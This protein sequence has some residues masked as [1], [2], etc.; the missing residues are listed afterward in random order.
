MFRLL[1]EEHLTETRDYD[2]QGTAAPQ[3]LK[4]KATE[5]QSA[6]NTLQSAAQSAGAGAVNTA[7]STLATKAGE[8]NTAANNISGGG[9]EALRVQA[10]ALATAAGSSTNNKGLYAAA[11][12]LAGAPDVGKAIAVI[13]AFK[14][15]TAKYNDLST[16]P[17]YKQ[18]KPSQGSTP[19]EETP[20]GKVNAVETAWTHVKEHF[21]ALCMAL[22]KEFA[23]QVATNATQLAGGTGNHDH[24]TNVINCFDVVVRAYNELSN[25]DNMDM[26]L[27]IQTQAASISS[28]AADS[29]TLSTPAN[30][31]NSAA[32]TLSGEK[33]VAN[34]QAF[35]NEYDAFKDIAN[36]TI[37]ITTV[38]SNNKNI[39]VTN[40]PHINDTFTPRKYKFFWIIVPS[41]LCGQ[42]GHQLNSYS[43]HKVIWILVAGYLTKNT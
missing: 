31:L 2:I 38:S 17:T 36:S 22:I 32:E 20:Q 40:L 42:T 18:N 27:E 37:E 21:Q 23:N 19:G 10:Q 5:V 11:N 33:T 28:N 16:H 41:P 6:A 29:T 30:H 24:A 39:E 9:L 3:T 4:T 35:K 25:P 1:L 26:A 34:A 13:T 7:A 12:D 43:T 15:V 14:N 8:L